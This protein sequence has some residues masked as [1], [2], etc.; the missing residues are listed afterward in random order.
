MEG[1]LGGLVNNSRWSIFFQNRKKDR[2]W[3]GLLCYEG[4][5]QKK[6][7]GAIWLRFLNLLCFI[8]M[9]K[10]WGGLKFGWSDLERLSCYLK[11]SLSER[12]I[13]M[14]CSLKFSFH[15]NFP[16]PHICVLIDPTFGWNLRNFLTLNQYFLTL[17]YFV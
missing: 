3:K 13:Y 2:A 11:C 9:T 12:L 4:S 8:Q 14:G 7:Y 10:I 15:P 6:T 16:P 17:R 5:N 1:N